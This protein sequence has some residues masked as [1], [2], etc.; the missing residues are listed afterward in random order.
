M[1]RLRRVWPNLLTGVAFVAVFAVSVA[2]LLG[3][4]SLASPAQRDDTS[5]VP[6]SQQP[7]PK[8]LS[9]RSVHVYPTG[10]RVKVLDRL[11][12]NWLDLLIGV[13]IVSVIAMIVATL[14]SDESLISLVRRGG[15]PEVPIRHTTDSTEATSNPA[16]TAATPGAGTIGTG[17]AQ[18][19]EGDLDSYDVFVPA[20]PGQ[21]A[22]G[23]EGDANTDSGSSQD[24]MLRAGTRRSGNVD[25]TA[26]E[27]L[28]VALAA[29]GFRVAAGA[30]LSREAASTVA[31]NY[32]DDGYEVV[33]EQQDDVYLLWIGPYATQADADV[34]AERII[35]DGGEALVY[36]YGDGSDMDAADTVDASTPVDAAAD[37]SVTESL[38]PNS[39]NRNAN[40]SGNEAVATTTNAGTVTIAVG[41]GNTAP[42]QVVQRYLQVGA[43]AFDKN[44][45]PLR[46]Q[47]A[48]LGLSVTRDEDGGGL[49][50]LYVGPFSGAQLTQTRARLAAQEIDSFPAVP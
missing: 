4:R 35:A 42:N 25:E 27:Q 46:A 33:V 22:A 26:K 39:R 40:G 8:R 44:A 12:R 10:P 50:R 48:E 11:R 43:F 5:K 45:R 2:K 31:Q 18:T 9:P 30:L 28:P 15:P 47:L 17:A 19:R 41:A 16:A 3:S 23:A 14:S 24:T 6:I 7:K 36:T 29:S 49:V 38:A 32:R 34:T 20:V 37:R 21:L 1:D 13:A